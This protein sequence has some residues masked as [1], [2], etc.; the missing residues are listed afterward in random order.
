MSD[1]ASSRTSV[2]ADSETNQSQAK[3]DELKSLVANI[4]DEAKNSGATAAAVGAED[5]VGL[6]V[7]A[8]QGEVE[9]VEFAHERSFGITVYVGQRRGSAS[10]TDSGESAIVDTVRAALNI[11]KY[12][13]SDPHAGLAEPELMATVFPDLD[14]Y[15]PTPLDPAVD[16]DRAIETETA[17]LE[18]DD[19]IVNSEGAMVASASRCNVYGNTNGFL[20]GERSTSYSVA[21]SVIAADEHG[22]QSGYWYSV[23]RSADDLDDD[24]E[25]GRVAARRTVAQ[26]GSKP[27]K[28]GKYPVLFEAPVAQT[29]IGHLI[30]A[31]SGGVQYRQTTFLLDSLGSQVATDALT[32]RQEPYLRRAAGSAAFDSDGVATVPRDY[33]TDGVVTSYVLSTYTARQLG[34]QTTGNADGCHNLIVDADTVPQEDLLRQMG[35]GLMVTGLMGQGVNMVTGDY[36]RGAIGFWIENGE[37]VHAVQEVTVAAN[38]KDV[39]ENLVGFGNDVDTRSNIR[40]GSILVEGMTV[41][42]N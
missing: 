26:L 25:T 38:L 31:L 33:L 2:S 1:I 17:A 12:T 21:A 18:Y 30:G 3:E 20:Q 5:N 27:I 22:A 13:E 19:R 34:L 8:R 35:T 39:Y 7:T 16:S 24:R 37:V 42:A 28:T 23:G 10:T 4:L 6:T 14:I 15:H 9:N 11:A 29:L 41:A 36:S 40:S 32:L